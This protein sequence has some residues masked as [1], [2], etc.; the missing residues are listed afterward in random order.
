M[1]FLMLLSLTESLL[2]GYHLISYDRKPL[3]CQSILP[4]QLII[5]D[6]CR[7]RGNDIN[8]IIDDTAKG[9]LTILGGTFCRD[10]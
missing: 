2:T 9:G 3:V 1:L 10:S 8:V 5:V 6:I 4:N 7:I